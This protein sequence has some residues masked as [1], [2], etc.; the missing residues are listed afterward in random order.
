MRMGLWPGRQDLEILTCFPGLDSGGDTSQRGEQ[1]FGNAVG[2][3]HNI[4]DPGR[5]RSLHKLVGFVHGEHQYGCVWRKPG[6]LPSGLQTVHHG[7]LEIH[8]H[9]IGAKLNHFFDGDLAIL[10]FAAHVPGCIRFDATPQQK[11]DGWTV[12]DDQN[13]V[14]HS[15][16]PANRSRSTDV[17]TRYRSFDPILYEEKGVSGRYCTIS[18]R[19]KHYSVHC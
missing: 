5:L 2:F 15:P 14:K 13:P 18:N 12:I 4:S 6:D 10:S 1:L 11:T 19:V 3:R 17:S 9:R 16:S 8:D 7:H